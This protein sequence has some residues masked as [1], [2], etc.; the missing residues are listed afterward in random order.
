[1]Q[2]ANIL[3]LEDARYQKLMSDRRKEALY[4][5]QRQAISRALEKEGYRLYKL[6]GR[7]IFELSDPGKTRIHYQD[8]IWVCSDREIQQLINQAIAGV[9]Q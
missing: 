6:N 7:P 5:A 8:G 3:R 9:E 4:A 2:M 1:M